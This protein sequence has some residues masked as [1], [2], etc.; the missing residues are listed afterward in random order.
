MKQIVTKAALSF[1]LL[2][3]VVMGAVNMPFPQQK[4]YAGCIKPDISQSILNND[5]ISAYEDYKSSF[6]RPA[7]STPGGYY[8][9]SKDTHSG[10][11]VIT[12][13]E[14]HGW[15]MTI[16]ALMAGYDDNART[17]FD[18]MVKFYEAHK[19]TG[20]G[21]NLMAWRIDGTM[22]YES[23]W[24]E[25]S[26]TDGDMD[27]AYGLLLGY[28]Q[29][30]DVSYLNK[31]K[32]IINDIYTAEVNP[33]TKA[34]QLG[35][36]V[37]GSSNAHYYHSRPSDWM[38]A[39]LR[40]FGDATGDSKWDA[41]ADE[42]YNMYS[43]FSSVNPK[44]PLISDFVY[45]T[46]SQTV[47]VQ[48]GF[49]E[50]TYDGEFYTNASRVPWKIATDYAMYGKTPAKDVLQKINNF[51]V[52]KTSG[53]PSRIYPGYYVGSGDPI[54]TNYTD[55]A[56]TAPL[57]AAQI[58]GGDQDF[59][60]KGWNYV[61]NMQQG[62][63]FNAA[64]KLQ[65]M[66]LMS[67]NWW[68][69]D[70]APS[71]IDT[72]KFDT[73]GVVF[74]DFADDDLTQTAMGKRFGLS[75]YGASDSWKAG[76]YWYIY[77]AGSNGGIKS[78]SGTDITDETTDKM[79]D[80]DGK[81]LDVKIVKTGTI[82][83]AFPQDS[84]F[85]LTK[86]SG[87]TIE[88]KGSGKIRFSM[89]TD[90]SGAL[91]KDEFWGGFGYEY[92][93]SS[94]M[95][96]E[97][98][99]VDLLN[100]APYSKE[101]KENWKWDADGA[102]T[103][104]GF[105]I[106]SANGED[107]T[108]TLN[109]IKFN[110][111]TDDDFG[112]DSIIPV[113]TTPV[114]TTPLDTTGLMFDDFSNSYGD[115]NSQSH[116]GALYGYS[117]NGESWTGGGY[118]YGYG[119][120]GAKLTNGSG[121]EITEENSGD[122]VE[123]GMMD[124][125]FDLSAGDG[126]FGAA[127]ECPLPDTTVDFHDLSNL[128]GVIIKIKGSGKVRFVFNTEV[129]DTGWHD[130]YGYDITLDGTMQEIEINASEL[131]PSKYSQEDVKNYTWADNGSKSVGGVKITSTG[132]SAAFQIESIKFSGLKDRDL[133]FTAKVYDP[134]SVTAPVVSNVASLSKISSVSGVMKTEL[135]LPTAAAVQLT[136]VNLQGRILAK[137]SSILK[138]GVN[139]ISMDLSNHGTGIYY[140]IAKSADFN[141]TK[142]F[143]LR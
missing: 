123:N 77:D 113:D 6:L 106:A 61:K 12:V 104:K 40:S 17:Y 67:G 91:G 50:G 43:R 108:L 57:V 90:N 94:S 52:S 41:V 63:A 49:L 97:E 92:D 129:T 99:P 114:D 140:V 116:L 142:K 98:I 130:G 3:S 137:Q 59:L 139:T 10:W 30:G 132:E 115:D 126:S 58:A 134:V 85:N 110:G 21:P 13:S 29:W 109:S 68:D 70:D 24:D 135:S 31:A 46:G 5:V 69:Y 19:A 112:I 127:V 25:G 128:D 72:T 122:L 74:D 73:S 81:T 102:P 16:M 44:C 100:Y 18:G 45:N 101:Q 133:N 9:Y 51:I 89:V 86:M 7:K 22:D 42:I 27:I 136:V 11:N 111:M 141:F 47:A 8:I 87:L 93:L 79:F 105:R 2:A 28:K 62:A 20:T 55:V 76:S 143:M 83:V 53:A 125:K 64:I 82:E 117:K 56:F 78:G 118:W 66:I 75:T 96:T 88:A 95:K 4:N 103:V 71:I 23:S 14:A 36:Y 119:Y 39:T 37:Y 32:K 138:A 54:N 120:G 48:Q 34:M 84:M 33:E 60:T 107:V 124:V 26:A 38:G 1:S 65:S 131:K 80:K 35:N 15:G 121:V